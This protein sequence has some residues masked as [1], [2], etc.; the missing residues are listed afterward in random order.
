MKRRWK[1][2]IGFA[3]VTITAGFLFAWT[4][5]PKMILCPYR[6]DVRQHLSGLDGQWTPEAYD[7][8]AED[9]DVLTPDS[10][11]LDAW[12]IHS[13]LDT[14]IGT[15][16]MLHGIGSCKESFLSEAKYLA[17][18]GLNVVLFD[19]R[20]QGQSSGSF[21]TYGFEEKKDVKIFT[22]KILRQFP[23]TPIGL[24]GVSLG[25]AIA[26]QSLA[27][28]ERLSFGIIEC[29][30]DELTNVVREYTARHV[31]FHCDWMADFAL[32]RS[33]K[34]A[35]FDSEEVSPYTSAKK[36]QVPVFVAHGTDDRNIPF[37]MGKKNFG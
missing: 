23:D 33:E 22:D 18:L 14:S 8:T 13:Q 37:E 19:L 21:C 29:T 20:A 16:I 17:S 36:I 1:I 15:I 34:L 10:V 9:Y 35:G 4:S 3:S 7:L 12:L 26:Y 31:G 24:Y 2:L 25:G 5:L 30:Y 11:K 28:D 32:W 6:F 27:Y